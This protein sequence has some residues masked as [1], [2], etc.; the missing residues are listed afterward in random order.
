MNAEQKTMLAEAVNTL[1]D[2]TDATDLY[3]KM[4][5]VY[6]LA[7]KD[8][9]VRLTGRSGVLNPMLDL[10]LAD[11][12][13]GQVVLRLI[14]TKRTTRGL[15]QL[16]DPNEARKIYMRELMATRRDRLSRLLKLW[17]T[18]RPDREKVRGA[19]KTEFERVHGNRWFAVR[20][21]REKALREQHG[22]RLSHHER[23]SLIKAFWEDV[24]REL[25]DFDVFVR[26]QMKPGADRNAVFQFK[27]QPRKE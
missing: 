2:D 26:N 20:E 17:N 13:G 14:E 9:P 6:E 15:P 25:D 27:L 24:N 21:E 1:I 7:R 5:G 11:Y 10:L 23:T 12:E 22:R 3:K 4:M 19:A 8:F 16:E 18:L